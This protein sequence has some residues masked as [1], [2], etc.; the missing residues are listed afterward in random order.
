MI[1][2]FKNIPGYK[3]LYQAS[4]LG[5]IKSLSKWDYTHYTK[6]KNL[7]PLND[8]DG[9]HLIVLYKNKKPKMFKIH[10]LVLLT[11]KGKSKLPC[12]HK[13]G[14]KS[15]NRLC[16][17]EYCTY[18]ENICHAFKIG[19]M[20]NHKIPDTKGE[21]NT[22]AKL[23]EKDIIFIRH[24]KNKISIKKL[25]NMFKISYGHTWNIINDKKWRHI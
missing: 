20:K 15:D 23:K 8:K 3:G 4:N 5:N 7:K 22:H 10:R 11:F 19:L 17:L 6:E 18:S 21:K 24:N 16:N 12:N 1:E 25:A 14:I 2:I 13:N 9:Y